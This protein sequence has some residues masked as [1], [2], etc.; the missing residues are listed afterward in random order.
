MLHRPKLVAIITMPANISLFYESSQPT[1]DNTKLRT[2]ECSLFG[3]KSA[4]VFKIDR[5]SNSYQ[6][7]WME[8]VDKTISARIENCVSQNHHSF[9]GVSEMSY[10]LIYCFFSN[11]YVGCQSNSSDVRMGNTQAKTNCMVAQVYKRS[12]L[13]NALKLV[14]MITLFAIIEIN[15]PVRR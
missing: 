13:D 5:I 15:L 1:K 7:A 4:S 2:A 14:N 6:F 10:F 8:N 11:R 9:G 12:L 3:V